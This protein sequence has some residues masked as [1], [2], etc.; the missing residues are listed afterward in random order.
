VDPIMSSPKTLARTAGLFYLIVAVGGAI[1]EIYVRPRIFKAGDAA[2]TADNIRAS[3]GLFRFG[4]LSELV[5]NT[6]WLL[7]AMVLYMLFKH[8]HQLAAAAMV[9]FVTA[10]AAIG[11]LNLVNQYTALTIATGEDYQRAFGQPSSDALTMLFV[12]MHNNGFFV[13]AVFFGLWLAPLGY[14]VI[15][16]GYVPKVLG[17]LLIIGCFGYIADEFIHFIAP[18]LGKSVSLFLAAVGGIP[19]LIFVVWL[20]AKAVPAVVAEATVPAKADVDTRAP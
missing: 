9:T 6:F 19:E 3:A 10:G 11:G 12:G 13:N 17:V 8:V 4:F 2:A 18:G 7:T 16:S 15:K 1:N 14:L 20:L 5:S